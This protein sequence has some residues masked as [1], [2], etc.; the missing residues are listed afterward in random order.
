MTVGDRISARRKEL[1]MSADT[2]AEKLGVSRS[3]IF[4]YENGSIEKLPASALEPI[5]AILHTTVAALMGWENVPAPAPA[6][7]EDE[8]MLIQLFRS[9]PEADRPL[10]LG[11]IRAALNSKGLL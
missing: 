9:V 2:L 6:L 7:S 4:R 10:V 3:T 5:A 8:E 11:M 1:G